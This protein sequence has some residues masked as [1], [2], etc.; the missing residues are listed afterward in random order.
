MKKILILFLIPLQLVAQEKGKVFSRLHTIDI[1]TKKIDT[2]WQGAEHIEAPNWS[3]DGSYLLM[4][5]EGRLYRWYLNRSK[6]FEL[7]NTAFADRCNN[8]H[9]ISADGK[10]LAI[11]H[12]PVVDSTNGKPVR[13]SVVYVLPIDGG[14]PRRITEGSPSYWHGWSPDGKTLVYCAERNGEYDVYAI[15]F[16][17]GNEVKLT[18][19]KGLDDGPE[20]SPDGKYIYYN[21]YADGS[22]EIW[23]MR[24]DG[25]TKEQLTND[26]HSNWF[27]H[28]S[29]DGKWIVM[30]SYVEDQ[31]QAHPFGKDVLLRL[32]NLKT[33]E[34]SNLTP[35]FFGGQGTINVPSWSPDSKKLAFVSYKNL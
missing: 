1:E 6:G 16:E 13:E 23:R 14:T 33:R 4:N 17:G 18:D 32:M 31:K 30:I 20:Y 5:K 35:V 8:D 21:S 34:I 27:A 25:S 3:T 2:V 11:S 22:M 24:P 28:P 26:R 19:A 15:P 10:W 7:L 29:P 12:S 9:G